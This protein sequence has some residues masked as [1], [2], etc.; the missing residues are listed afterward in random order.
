MFGSGGR[1]REENLVQGDVAYIP[2]GFG[3]S[4][5]NIAKTKARIL[6]VFNNGHYQTI[7]LSQWIAGNPTD[8]LG[9]NFGVDP[10]IFD[11]FPRKEVFLTK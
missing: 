1:W 7:N 4:I 9:T 10:A 8:I 6:I 11:K 3:H 5:K 2:Q